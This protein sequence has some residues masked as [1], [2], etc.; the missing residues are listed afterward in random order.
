MKITAYG[1]HLLTAAGAALGLWSIL[2]IFEGFYKEAIW[3]LGIAVL[4]DSVDGSLARYVNVKVN[5]PRFDG[6]LMDNL[7]DYITWT[8]APLFWIYA[9][10][11][12]PVW[13]LMICAIASI[14]GFTNIEA[15]T[16][17]H[18]FTGFP[19]YWNIVVLYLFLLDIPDL[20]ATVCLLIFA[21]STFLP[22]KFV[23]PTRTEFLKIPT[24]IFGSLFVVQL[25]LIVILFEKSPVY[26]IY[27]SFLF[28]IY[29]FAL[30]FYLNL[31]TDETLTNY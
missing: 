12:I 3:V 7:V 10:M 17:D 11:H 21:V 5:A 2:L 31:K 29:Y 24:L 26:L 16:E 8:V 23:Y 15:K 13:V 30:S 4:I 28:P 20:F 9:T 14:F 22:V 18:Y 6:A 19:S 25:A 1:V 27:S